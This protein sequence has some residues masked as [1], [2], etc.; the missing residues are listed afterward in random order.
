MDIALVLA[1]FVVGILVGLT[2]M[3]GG[4]LMTPILV[5]LVGVKPTIAVGTD[6]FYAAFTKIIGG[7]VHGFQK[8]VS[9]RVAGLLLAGSLPGSLVAGY[10]LSQL[11]KSL[12]DSLE[13]AIA[14]GLGIMLIVVAISLLAPG[15]KNRSEDGE[16]NWLSR[17]KKGKEA[18]LPVVGF[19][20]GFLVTLT[21]IG[22]GTLICAT[23]FLLFPSLGVAKI[24]GTD[25][26]HAAALV[27]VAAASH[28]FIGDVDMSLAFNLMAGSVPGI[29]IGSRLVVSFPEKVLRFSM[30]GV[31]LLAG[32]KL[33]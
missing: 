32:I 12:G 24:V 9:V 7:T 15:M 4:S 20:V 8:T 16:D 19:I 17:L 26:A 30:S 10:F 6:L 27:S 5:L 22:S 28:L 14:K 11:K 31:M 25:V 1:G 29:M 33:V 21:S 13:D 18:V 3:G 2:G 23:L